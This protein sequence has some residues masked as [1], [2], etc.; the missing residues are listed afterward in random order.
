MRFLSNESLIGH[1]FGKAFDIIILNMLFI[2]CSI[3]VITIGASYSAMYYAFFK[4]MREKDS[5]VSKTFFEGFKTNFK[6]AT[7]AWLS[8]VLLIIILSVDIWM[9][10]PTG[11]MSF[12]PFYY[13]LIIISCII[14]FTIMYL[15]PIISIFKNTLKNLVIFSFFFAAKNILF[16]ILIAFLNTFPLF[17]IFTNLNLFFFYF[18]IWIAFGFGLIAFINSLL[19]I[20]LFE[21]YLSSNNTDS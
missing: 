8:V 15:F 12:T 6:Q 3:P 21:S 5:S 10:G 19:F 4:K 14:A 2:L 18:S 11:M 17:F 20:K 1:F 16:T 9:F 13:L 7:L